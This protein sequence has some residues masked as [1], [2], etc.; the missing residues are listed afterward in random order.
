[1]SQI[2]LFIARDMVHNLMHASS[3]F[4]F[5]N[6]AVRLFSFVQ[7]PVTL[8]Y[9]TSRTTCTLASLQYKANSLTDTAPTLI[10]N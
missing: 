10:G 2:V 8:N 1:M 6:S 3:N 9:S 4:K 5:L 7:L